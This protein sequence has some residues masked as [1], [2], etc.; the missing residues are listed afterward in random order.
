VTSS[1]VITYDAVVEWN[2][3]TIV[4]CQQQ[5]A[6]KQHHTYIYVPCIRRKLLYVHVLQGP[7]KHVAVHNTPSCCLRRC[8]SPSNQRYLQSA[9]TSRQAGGGRQ[10]RMSQLWSMLGR[11]PARQY[12][13]F[14]ECTRGT[15]LLLSASN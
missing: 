6:A 8:D 4:P 2:S 14:N 5:L 10:G 3:R 13:G 7:Q 11:L 15:N 9:V 12:S 1:S